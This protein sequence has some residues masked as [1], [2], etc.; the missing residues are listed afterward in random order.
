[1]PVTGHGGPQD[2]EALRLPHSLHNWLTG[3]TEDVS[4]MC[5]L[6]FT[7]RKICG[8]NLF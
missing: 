3:A 6:L 4:L 8:T 2:C 5:W 7:P 1:M